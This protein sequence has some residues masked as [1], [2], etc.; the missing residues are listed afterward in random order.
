MSFWKASGLICARPWKPRSRLRGS[1]I[2]PPKLLGLPISPAIET[3]LNDG[4]HLLM[5]CQQQLQSHQELF[6]DFVWHGG[7][8]TQNHG[9][10][11]P[12]GL[13]LLLGHQA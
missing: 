11:N 4:R 12:G 6:D 9:A 10:N 1:L 7:Q 5:E 3:L 13:L 8:R 2:R